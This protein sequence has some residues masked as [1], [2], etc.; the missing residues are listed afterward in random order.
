MTKALGLVG[1][2]P[3][4]QRLTPRRG[5]VNSCPPGRAFLGT[6]AAQWGQIFTPHPGWFPGTQPVG[7]SAATMAGCPVHLLGVLYIRGLIRLAWLGSRFRPGHASP[8]P[9][10]VLG[11]PG[12]PSRRCHPRFWR[13]PV[14]RPPG[15]G[16]VLRMHPASALCD[17][18]SPHEEAEGVAAG[19]GALGRSPDPHTPTCKAWRGHGNHLSCPPSAPATAQA[20]CPCRVV[21]A[22]EGRVRGPGTHIRGARGPIDLSRAR[23]ALPGIGPDG[24]RSRWKMKSQRLGTPT[25]RLFWAGVQ[26]SC[27][28]GRQVRPTCGCRLLGSSEAEPSQAGAP[29]M[30]LGLFRHRLPE[31]GRQPG[32]GRAQGTLSL[33]DDGG[34]GLDSCLRLRPI[35]TLVPGRQNQFT[36]GYPK[37]KGAAA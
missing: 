36:Q 4:H 34:E 9:R 8:H 28:A 22:A 21:R 3:P 2:A 12:F 29:C 30:V 24:S 7:L 31:A 20:L 6:W 17:V 19:L 25:G 18:P 15:E 10:A 27:R 14:S 11:R 16:R 35:C 37:T 26:C 33:L 23:S 32:L 5:D 13:W 1:T